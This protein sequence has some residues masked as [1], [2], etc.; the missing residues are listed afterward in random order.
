M[1]NTE[2]RTVILAESSRVASPLSC[3]HA[4]DENSDQ[5]FGFSQ[6][7]FTM[8]AVWRCSASEK[9]S[10]NVVAYSGVGQ[11]VC[12]FNNP[13]GVLQQSVFKIV[14]CFLR[15]CRFGIHLIDPKRFRFGVRCSA[16]VV[17]CFSSH[18]TTGWPSVMT[19][20]SWSMPASRA[21]AS[22]RVSGS[23]NGS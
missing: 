9:L 14:I 8:M 21:R 1:V 22:S 15:G 12:Q 16:F 5:F 3:S 20:T 10:C 19:R 7:C 6:A 17:R 23:S 11:V 13:N 4:C 18:N 2:R